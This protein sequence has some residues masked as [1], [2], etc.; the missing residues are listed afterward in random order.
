[1]ELIKINSKDIVQKI[2]GNPQA[3]Y[4]KLRKILG[5]N[6]PF[7]EMQ[8][9]IG[10][11]VWSAEGNDWK[12]YNYAN[13]T[14]KQLIERQLTLQRQN[15]S[16]LNGMDS[17]TTDLLF[18]YPDNDFLF[19]RTTADGEVEIKIAGWGYR[20]AFKPNHGGPI[21]TS[22]TDQKKNPISIAFLRDSD[23]IPNNK[24]GIAP[25]NSQFKS[26]DITQ[27]TTD[28]QGVYHFADI[29]VGK[30]LKLI[31]FSTQKVFDL[32]VMEG[33]SLYEFIVET[34]QISGGEEG[35]GEEGGG[36]EGGGGPEPPERPKTID[37]HILVEGINGFIG[38]NY[39]ITILIS[40]NTISAETDDAGRYYL[41]TLAE[42][43]KLTV[44]DGLNPDNI[45][46]FEIS[47]DKDEYI[48]H[49]PYRATTN[50]KDIKC[51]ILDAEQK[52]IHS[53]RVRFQQGD[54]DVLCTLDAEGTTWFDNSTFE[55]DKDIIVTIYGAEKDYGD[56]RF[57]TTAD[58][59]EYILQERSMKSKTWLVIMSAI[60]I[61]LWFATLIITSPFITDV[62]YI[63]GLS[64]SGQI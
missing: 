43:V 56:I 52:P 14:E 7:A 48:F 4:S 17:N 47:V 44:T 35:G 54:R 34:T 16:S 13:V 15:I 6:I 9:G 21:T 1:M 33:K 51:T 10:N 49:V 24:F 39:P 60:F 8:S 59:K 28:E 12:S 58:E 45:Q 62:A 41:P 20:K 22:F 36:E 37:A 38:T 19:F 26:A 30:H 53:T 42:G 57:S 2:G 55:N 5:D 32:E 64:L 18:T 11:Y 50:N 29:P 40:T 63:L 25:S 61:V 3:I 31:D 46:E 23:P 27:Y